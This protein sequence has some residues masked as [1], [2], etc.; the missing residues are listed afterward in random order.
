VPD[1]V[2]F[3]GDAEEASRF[4]VDCWR[5]SYAGISFYPIWSTDYMRWQLFDVPEPDRV[6]KLAAYD[7]G[8]LVGLWAPSEPGTGGAIPSGNSM[9]RLDMKAVIRVGAFGRLT[10]RLRATRCPAGPRQG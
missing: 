5:R 2:E 6:H 1:I 3:E 7:D 10:P 8:A 4:A 9:N